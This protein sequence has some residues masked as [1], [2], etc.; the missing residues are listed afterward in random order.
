ML[1]RLLGQ[2]ME[3]I[4][5]FFGQ[6]G[7]PIVTDEGHHRRAD[8]RPRPEATRG[9]FTDDLD[10]I[11]E[12]RPHT[13]KTARLGAL[14]RRQTVRHLGL[15]EHRHRLK[16]ALLHE[17][18]QNARARLIRQVGDHAGEGGARAGGCL[19]GRVELGESVG[20]DEDVQGIARNHRELRR[21]AERFG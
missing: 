8:R 12:L 20:M 14:F 4:A 1:E 16:S 2:T 21:I 18:Q 10:V 19:R 7:V 17:F 5:L 3:Q 9:H 11:I 15:H 6:S 13:G